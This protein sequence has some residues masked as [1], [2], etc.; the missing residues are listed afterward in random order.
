VKTLRFD[1]A[2]EKS[3]VAG[4]FE[5]RVML[6]ESYVAGPDRSI[7]LQA[8]PTGARAVQVLLQ[9]SPFETVGNHLR[10]EGGLTGRTTLRSG[11]PDDG[12]ATIACSAE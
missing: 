5:G 11:A 10:G 2:G 6:Q 3:F 1:A 7:I 4:A 12:A 9:L 8:G